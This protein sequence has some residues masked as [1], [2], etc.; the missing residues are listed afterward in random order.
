MIE[1]R[2]LSLFGEEATEVVIDMPGGGGSESLVLRITPRAHGPRGAS[3]DLEVESRGGDGSA[4]VVQRK[5]LELGF[6]DEV[7]IHGLRGPLGP[8]SVDLA[9]QR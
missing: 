1:E 2:R 3:L 4:R 6:T 8:V 9:P 7:R 5:R